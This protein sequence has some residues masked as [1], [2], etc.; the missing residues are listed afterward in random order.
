MRSLECS[1]P[2][3]WCKRENNSTSNIYVLGRATTRELGK[4]D[5]TQ[6]AR[7]C[8]MVGLPTSSACENCELEYLVH[9]QNLTWSKCVA[10]HA[11]L[12]LNDLLIL[13]VH[14]T[15]VEED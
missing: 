9:L 1:M 6:R 8:A 11:H 3:K 15:V 14:Q 5:F 12:P 4:S 13:P 7:V 10:Q 2:N